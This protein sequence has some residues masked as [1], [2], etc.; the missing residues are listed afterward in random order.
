MARV[1]LVLGVTTLAAGLALTGCTTA[2]K[3]DSGGAKPTAAIAIASDVTSLD[4]NAGAVAADFVMA[5]MLYGSLVRRDEGGKIIG[6]LASA[7]K[8]DADAKGAEFTLRSD[9][10]CTDGAKVAASGVAKSLTRFAQLPTAAQVFG[11]TAAQATFTGDD[12]SGKI[13]IKLAAPWSDLLFGLALPQAGIVCPAAL[14]NADLIKT[15]GKGAGTGPYY[16]SSSK[17]GDVYTLAAV[18]GYTGTPAY[19]NLPQGTVPAVVEMKVRQ[20]EATQA[21]ELISGGLDY[22]GITGADAARFVPLKDKFTIKPAPIVRMMAVFNERKGHPG[23][24]PAF[25]EAVAK[26]LDAKAF[27][28][29]VTRGTGSPMF[30]ITDAAVPCANKDASLLTQPDA[31]GAKA[32]LKGVKV[33]VVGTNAVAAGAGNEYVQ[34]TLKAAGADVQLRNVDSATWGNDVISNKGDWDLTVWPNLNLTNLLTTP[35][36]FLTGPDPAAKGRNFPGVNDPAF[37]KAFGTAMATSDETAKCAAWADAQKSLLKAHHVL[38]L[39]A[40]NVNYITSNRVKALSPD[41]LFD[42]STLRIVK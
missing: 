18:D 3:E 8:S 23:A 10:T 28:Q 1:P 2:S 21:N 11:P 20:S 6:G 42:P 39:A 33:K 19:A 15:G 41:G 30:T 32:A 14:D 35:A 16:V 22:S 4:P 9:V 34:A 38:P 27:N 5:R 29:A 40:V 13:T 36:S 31:E 17:P 26:A 24:D 7:W 25:R 37:T 12:A